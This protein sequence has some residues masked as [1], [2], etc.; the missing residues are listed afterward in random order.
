MFASEKILDSMEVK[1]TE[2]KDK[3]NVFQWCVLPESIWAV[4][5]VKTFPVPTSVVTT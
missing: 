4:T 1:P 5:D 2:A 3:S